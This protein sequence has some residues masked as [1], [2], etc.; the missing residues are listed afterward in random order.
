MNFKILIDD[1]FES[2]NT[3]PELNPIDKKK[4][5]SIINDFEDGKWRYNEFQN[6]VWDNIAETALSFRERQSL[7]NQPLSQLTEAAKKLRLTDKEKDISKGSELAEIVLYGLMKSHFKALPVVP[8]IY[9][10]QNPKDNAKGADSVHIVVEKDDFTLWFGEAKFYSSIDDTR[11]NSII[12]SVEN[13][14]RTD[15]IKKENSIV[16]DLHD[17]DY[18]VE[19]DVLNKKIK[20]ALSPKESLDSLKPK[21]HIP[22]LL[23][24]ECELT[25]SEKELN[26]EYKE[27]IIREHKERAQSYFEKQVKKISDKVYKY[28]EITFHIILFPVPIKKNIIDEFVNIA[29]FHQNR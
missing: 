21:L 23:L 27:N 24:H 20:R 9:Y 12:T 2:F 29:T 5:I 19:E 13:S 22:I 8:K 10:K 3:A 1:F 6:F 18:L 11:L 25:K 26:Q 15:K 17:I 7:I 14:L 28:S 4:V 16:T